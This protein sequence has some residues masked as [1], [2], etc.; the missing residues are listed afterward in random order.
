MSIPVTIVSGYL[1]A[2]KTS[3]INNVLGARHGLRVA[4]LVNDFGAINIDATLIADAADDAVSLTNGCVCCAIQD[5]LGSA[6]NS[7]TRRVPPPEHILLE[8]S[9]VAE[10]ARMRRY[11]EG[12]PGVH[13][14]AVVTLVDVETV[15]TRVADKFVG[16]VVG[17][18]LAAAD[19]LVANKS[20]LVAD[21]EYDTV[22]AWLANRVPTAH[23]AKARFGALAPGLLFGQRAAR[24]KVT[25]LDFGRTASNAFSTIQ[26][27]F[28]GAVSV[29]ALC[30]QLARLPAT[31]HRV[32]GY[33]TDRHTGERHLIQVVGQ[34]VSTST[35]TAKA[36][37]EVPDALVVIGTVVADLESVA[38]LVLS[39]GQ[40][41][42]S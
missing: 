23:I 24:P 4:V 1:G 10:P 14:N 33:I 9:G 18:Q 12:W 40:A 34:H 41:T 11:A 25:S 38:A 19:V 7:Q 6:L 42:S 13:L 20:D 2:G 17:R 3:L 21:T 16:R 22:I 15:R 26:I 32:K 39:H 29:D 8:C 30:A 35:V 28:P 36:S 31:V 27:P 5:D 37:A